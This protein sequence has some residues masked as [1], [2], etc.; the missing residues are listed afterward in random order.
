MRAISEFNLILRRN[1]SSVNGFLTSY[2]GNKTAVPKESIIIYDE[3]QRAWDDETAKAKRGT[4]SEPRDFMN[5]AK[6]KNGV[7]LVGLIGEGQ[8]I[9]TG[10]EVQV[11][12]VC[13]LRNLQ[14]LMN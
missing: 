5:V 4:C 7:V 13:S 10:E 9:N 8:E 12:L 6:K 2:G 14:L 11:I 3:A 1:F